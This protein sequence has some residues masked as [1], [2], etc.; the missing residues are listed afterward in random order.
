MDSTSKYCQ[1]ATWDQSSLFQG[2]TDDKDTFPPHLDYADQSLGFEVQTSVHKYGHMNSNGGC[3]QHSANDQTLTTDHIRDGSTKREVKA[4]S[5][6]QSQVNAGSQTCRTEPQTQPNPLSEHVKCFGSKTPSEWTQSV[7]TSDGTLHPEQVGQNDHLSE[8]RGSSEPRNP[9]HTEC[10]AKME[11]AQ[12]E[13]GS[14]CEKPVASKGNWSQVDLE[15]EHRKSKALY[16]EL[17]E[18]TLFHKRMNELCH[19]AVHAANGLQ[20]KLEEEIKSHTEAIN[21]IGAMRAKHA[22][23]RVVLEEEMEALLK[24]S[25]EKQT[26]LLLEI[27]ELQK[28]PVR[29]T[30]DLPVSETSLRSLQEAPEQTLTAHGICMKEDHQLIQ[31]F[32]AEVGYFQ[33]MIMKEVRDLQTEVHDQT[34]CSHLASRAVDLEKSTLI[35]ERHVDTPGHLFAPKP[36]MQEECIDEQK[37]PMVQRSIWKRLQNFLKMKGHKKQRFQNVKL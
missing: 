1:D 28:A 14:E 32:K 29:N 31:T 15:I 36:T 25:E 23:E 9:E 37:L 20:Q 7:P 30:H 6:E 4:E 8:E 2:Q 12:K 27:E 19:S 34:L 24:E 16:R 18:M 22:A 35:F 13:Q 33:A 26:A 11:G 3:F 17:Y 10:A 5:K 21:Q